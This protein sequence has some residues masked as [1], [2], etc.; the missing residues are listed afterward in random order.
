[1]CYVEK[2]DKSNKEDTVEEDSVGKTQRGC[3]IL[4]FSAAAESLIVL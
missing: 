3:V 2:V 4:F 1:M